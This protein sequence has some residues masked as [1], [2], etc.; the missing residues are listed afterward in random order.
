MAP[1]PSG[2]GRVWDAQ[3]VLL[4]LIGDVGD[5]AK[6]VQGAEGWRAPDDVS[7]RLSHELSDCLWSLLTLADKLGVDLEASFLAT[8]GELEQRLKASPAGDTAEASG[9]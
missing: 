1:A 4:G 6:A 2:N 9:T 3:Q 8:M 7:G 5:L